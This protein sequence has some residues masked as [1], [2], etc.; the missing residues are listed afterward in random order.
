MTRVKRGIIAKKRRKKILKIAKG[1]RGSSSSLFRTA[2][3]RILKA[4]Q[5][6]YNNSRTKKRVFRRLWITRLNASS[7]QTGLSY[8]KLLFSLQT[9][10]V[11]LN[12][13]TLSQ[14]AVFD[15][16]SFFQLIQNIKTSLPS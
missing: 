2:N 15:P 11:K 12:R 7:R 9:S 3:Q 13:K 10:S 5:Y 14:L 16:K 1:F 4:L 6:S 8:H